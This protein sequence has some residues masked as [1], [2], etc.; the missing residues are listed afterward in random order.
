MSRRV[1]RGGAWGE[2]T[3]YLRCAARGSRLGIP[4]DSSP[5]V[6]FRCARD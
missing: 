5:F 6:G 3:F 1:Y 2:V 4:S